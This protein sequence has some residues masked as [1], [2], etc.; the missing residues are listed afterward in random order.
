MR[1]R[2]YGRSTM[3]PHHPTQGFSRYRQLHL[4]DRVND[5]TT[6][7]FRSSQP[8]EAGCMGS[9]RHL[10][11]APMGR[12]KN[13]T[14]GV[15]RTS[16]WPSPSRAP[17]TPAAASLFPKASNFL[18]PGCH[19]FYFLPSSAESWE[20]IGFICTPQ[21]ISECGVSGEQGQGFS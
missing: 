9:M 2:P 16:V 8:L 21:Q 1:S 12:E 4:T 3:P 10:H 14:K 6:L 13:R 19:C 15:K 5:Y 20:D 11:H 18:R 17:I 7:R